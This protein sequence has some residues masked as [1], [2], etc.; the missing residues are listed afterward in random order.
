MLL[1]AGFL[2]VYVLI[3]CDM[4]ASIKKIQR[5]EIINMLVYGN[6]TAAPRKMSVT[7]TYANRTE[8]NHNVHLQL[9]VCV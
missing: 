5:E 2:L 4:Q 9:V 7:A 3:C 1:S 8:K 6:V